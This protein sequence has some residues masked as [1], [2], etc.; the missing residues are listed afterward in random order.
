MKKITTI[1]IGL[2]LTTLAF[3][4]TVQGVKIAPKIGKMELNGCGVRKKFMLKLYVA[5]LYTTEK[6][7]SGQEILDEDKESLIKLNIIS[8]LIN[9]ARLKEAIEEGFEAA[10][11]K[12]REAAKI[13]I[14][15][16]IKKIEKEK[17]QKKDEFEFQYKDN[18]VTTKLNGKEIVVNKGKAFKR[19]LFGIWLGET[20]IDSGLK[21]ELLK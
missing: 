6:G 2:L 9:T 19:A 1:V 4:K 20:A 7:K 3:G 14:E 10:P 17:I 21:K 12:D 18:T 8:G 11:K 15:K 13:E 5:S 16:F